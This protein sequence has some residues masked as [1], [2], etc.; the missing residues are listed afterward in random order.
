MSGPFTLPSPLE[1]LKNEKRW[2]NWKLIVREGKATKVPFRPNGINAKSND[3]SSWSSFADVVKSLTAPFTRLSPRPVSRPVSAFPCTPTCSGMPAVITWRTVAMPRMSFKPI[4]ATETFGTPC[5]TSG[6]RR[7]RSR[8]SGTNEKGARNKPIEAMKCCLCGKV[9]A[10]LCDAHNAAPLRE[11][12][13]CSKCNATRVIP[14]R[15]SL[16][17]NEEA[18][19]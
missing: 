17:R 8:R 5:A 2:V 1:P 18:D 12:F 16:L 3:S 14:F 13:C 9:I 19:G 11:D 7:G 6:C 10:H 15:I 4:S